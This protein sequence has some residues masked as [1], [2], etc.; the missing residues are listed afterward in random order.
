MKYRAKP[1][2][3]EAVKI[4]TNMS[5]IRNFTRGKCD[6]GLGKVTIHTPEGDLIAKE[7]DYIVKN[8]LGECYPCRAGVF[9]E[10]YEQI[11]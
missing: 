7:G 11:E 4:G 5:E 10:Q 2:V 1:F 6:I 3:V 8:S 9:E